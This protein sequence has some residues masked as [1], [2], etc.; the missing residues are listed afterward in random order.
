MWRSGPAHSAEVGAVLW[1]WGGLGTFSEPPPLPQVLE[2]R[3]LALARSLTQQLQ[4]SCLVLVSRLQGLPAHVQQE[5][6]CLSQPHEGGWGLAHASN[7][8]LSVGRV[9]LD[10]IR[11]SV[12]GVMD[13]MVNN[14]PLNWLVG[15]FYPRMVAMETA[16]ADPADSP[17]ATPPPEV[18]E[19]CEG[20][21]MESLRPHEDS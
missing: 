8:V 6:L 17:S 10:R 18:C 19:A 14:T 16:G 12:D 2:T 15:P 4:T 1:F 20:V 21:E 11:G 13:Y 9:R 7:G 3:T 5:A